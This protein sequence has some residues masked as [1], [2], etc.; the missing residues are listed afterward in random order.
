MQN[1]IVKTL[2]HDQARMMGYMGVRAMPQAEYAEYASVD[3]FERISG[4]TEPAYWIDGETASDEQSGFRPTEDAV[5]G[6]EIEADHFIKNDHLAF[7]NRMRAHIKRALTLD[8]LREIIDI[9]FEHDKLMNKMG[10]YGG[11]TD[12]FGVLNNELVARERMIRYQ[13][14]KANK[15]IP[16]TPRQRLIRQG[17]IKP[18]IHRV[19]MV[20]ASPE[21]VAAKALRELDVAA[22]RNVSAYNVAFGPTLEN[23]YSN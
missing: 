12:T 20:I 8:S 3:K 4:P 1:D 11:N 9:L 21:E 14:Q 6:L 7:T 15:P 16:E 23:H 17:I 2:E 5:L 13:L 18:T 19:A 22:I 10:M